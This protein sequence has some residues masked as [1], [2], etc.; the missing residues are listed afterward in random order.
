ML[1]VP[2]KGRLLVESSL[3]TVGTAIGSLGHTATTGAAASTKGSWVQVFA[4]TSFDAYL[5]EILVFNYSVSAGDSRLCVDI[6][7]GAAT[8]EILIPDLLCGG[9]STAGSVLQLG[10]GRRFIFPLYI[11]AGS[12]I[13]FRGAGDRV[14]TAFRAI[15]TL[16][17]GDSLPP[18][19][20]GRKVTTYGITT[21]PAGTAITPGASGAEGSWTDVGAPTTTTEDHFAFLP[22]YQNGLDTTKTSA[23]IMVDLGEGAAA[24]TPEQFGSWLFTQSSAETEE[25]PMPSLP[26]FKDIPSGSQ[27]AARASSHTTLDAGVENF[28]IHAVS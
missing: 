7:I 12:R 16:W 2:Q 23:G 28:V 17:G 19:R 5:I 25:G 8:E 15:I 9:A 21:V 24:S 3:P 18:F 20:V 13:T 1:W 10:I 22:G 27:L 6:G 26:V 4:S 11:P 14:S